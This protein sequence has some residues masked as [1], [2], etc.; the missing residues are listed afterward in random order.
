MMTNTKRLITLQRVG[1]LSNPV[2][3]ACSAAA[4]RAGRMNNSA[5]NRLP[6]RRCAPARCAIFVRRSDALRIQARLA[7][8]RAGA[9]SRASP[10]R[11]LGVLVALLLRS[12]GVALQ[13]QRRAL[14]PSAD[15]SQH[16]LVE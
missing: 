15:S 14:V 10:V 6:L 13:V 9:Q 1:L 7:P 12:N 4:N 8:L 5:I 3:S 16:A 2:D 11:S